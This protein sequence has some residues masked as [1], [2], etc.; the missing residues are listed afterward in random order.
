MLS[1]LLMKTVVA[2]DLKLDVLL[3]RKE[4]SEKGNEF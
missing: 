2:V 4:S 1:R 3:R